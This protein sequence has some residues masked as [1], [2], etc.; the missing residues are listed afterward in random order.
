MS[1]V[2]DYNS[3]RNFTR[4]T[5]GSLFGKTVVRIEGGGR[6]I[7]FLATQVAYRKL[8]L[9]GYNIAVRDKEIKPIE[10]DINKRSYWEEAKKWELPHEDRIELAK[11]IYYLSQK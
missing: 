6:T 4:V 5:I 9:L 1:S 10:Q 2:D 8:A 7:E 11:A 3:F